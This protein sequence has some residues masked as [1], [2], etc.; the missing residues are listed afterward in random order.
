MVSSE[1]KQ[2]LMTPVLSVESINGNTV[3]KEVNW[4]K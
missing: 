1:G 4:I 2:N 3:K